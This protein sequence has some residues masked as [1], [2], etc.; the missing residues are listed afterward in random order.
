[1]D[2]R[3]P[4]HKYVLFSIPISVINKDD[5]LQITSEFEVTNDT[6][7][8]LMIAS[9]IELCDSET[10]T[11]GIIVDQN[12]GFNINPMQH[13]GVTTKARA[14]KSYSYY[15]NKFLIYHLDG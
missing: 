12:N 3:I 15:D 4:F 6:L 8:N 7:I 14:Y 11:S 9:A 13:Y 1:M 5:V 10:S 2:T